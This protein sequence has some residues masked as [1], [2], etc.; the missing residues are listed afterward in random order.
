MPEVTVTVIE[1][2][3]PF[4]S[5]MTMVVVPP[6]T[7]VTVKVTTVVVACARRS[8]DAGVALW[9]TVAIAV[10]N[11]LA[12]NVPEYPGS[13]TVNV[14][15]PGPVNVSANDD[16]TIGGAVGPGIGV[17][18]F[19]PPQPASIAATVKDNSTRCTRRI[20][21]CPPYRGLPSPENQGS[22]CPLTYP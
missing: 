19:E 17:V 12:A 1:I 7:G 16:G 11:D 6:P 20:N 22:L 9:A 4:W 21:E 15:A 14:W 5:V 13:L 18:I 3:L 8:V 10:F 2:E